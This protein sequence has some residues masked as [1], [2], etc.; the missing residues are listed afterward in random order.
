MLRFSDICIVPLP[1]CQMFCIQAHH[2][3]TRRHVR[4]LCFYQGTLSSTS[5]NIALKTMIPLA[6]PPFS[7]PLHKSFMSSKS[8]SCDIS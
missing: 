3:T 1:K 2:S 8:D 5:L 7:A 4:G 6:Q